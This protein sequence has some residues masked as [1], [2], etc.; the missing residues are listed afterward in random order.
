[1]LANS[2]NQIFSSRLEYHKLVCF[3]VRAKNR[4]QN[5]WRSD[6]S[7][8]LWG[9]ASR[10]FHHHISVLQKALEVLVATWVT[11]NWNLVAHTWCLISQMLDGRCHRVC[12]NVRVSKIRIGYPKDRWTMGL[13]LRLQVLHHGPLPKC[14]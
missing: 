5:I 7:Q 2:Q 13:W 1:M 8:S 12:W 10:Q 6:C 11:K 3:P 14:T 4:P 9:I